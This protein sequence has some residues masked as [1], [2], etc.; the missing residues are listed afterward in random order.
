MRILHPVAGTLALA[1]ILVF[2]FS[3]ALAELSG[4]TETLRATK[5]AIPWG[6]LIL[7]PTLAFTGISGFRLGSK[8][9][10]PTV[11]AKK[12]R[13]PVIALNGLLVL[14]P[15]ALLLRQLALADDFGAV[16]YAVQAVELCAGALNI[17]LMALSFRD[18]L[19]LRRRLAA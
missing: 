10:H 1:T 18:G 3:T 2:W 8:W 9:K 7:V 11:A 13:M 15:C 6:L 4:S 14:A 19:R 16:F 12:K 17:T 5:L